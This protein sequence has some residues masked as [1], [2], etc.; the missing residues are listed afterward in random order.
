MQP[1]AHSPAIRRHV[2]LKAMAEDK[3]VEAVGKVTNFLIDPTIIRV[4]EGFNA[5]PINAEHVEQMLVS[6]LAGAT[7]PPLEVEVENGD[8]YVVDGHH[9]REMYL[10]ARKRG[11]D[12]KR[13]E[14]RQFRGEL[15]DRIMLM[16][17]SQQGLPLTPLQMGQ[18]Y[19]KLVSMGW[20]NAEIASRAGKSGQHVRDCLGLT[21]ADPKAKAMLE[22]GQVSADVVRT[23][24]RQHG[25][26][27][28]KVLEADLRHA[29]A[30]GKDKVT[31]A[32]AS[33][34][35]LTKAQRMLDLLEALRDAVEAL[36]GTSKKNETLVDEYWALM[37]KK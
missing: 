7:F 20:T 8:T 22:K 36:D 31:P 10:L 2:S 37:G 23:A 29:K 28:G 34:K 18:Q 32:T 21:E 30:E 16:V 35:P 3:D 19:A 12:V 9:R 24:M 26:D 13:V 11:H 17:T 4:K 5:R 6:F 15:A 14:A 1:K 27:A 33:A 25:A